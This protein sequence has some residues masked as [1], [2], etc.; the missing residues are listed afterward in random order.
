MQ[1]H[2]SLQ[3]AEQ[4]FD[5]EHTL[6]LGLTLGGDRY[7]DAEDRKAFFDQLFSRL[8]A[9]PGLREAGAVSKLPLQGGTNGR[10]FT[11]EMISVD[12]GGRGVLTENSTVTGDYFGAMG[13]PLLAGRTLQPEDDDPESPGVVINRAAAARFWPDE[14]PLGKRLSFGDDPP[15]WLTVVGVV[16]D[17]RQWGPGVPPRPEAYMGY[18]VN[19]RTRM[20]I[21]VAGAGDPRGLFRP[22]RDAVLAVDPNQPLSEIQTMG[23]ILESQLAGREFYTFLIGLFSVLAL[24]LAAA[25]VYGVISY[26]VAQ[27][28][29]ELGIRVALGAGRR[30]LI[31]LVVRRAIV[32]VLAGIGFGLVGVAVATLTISSLLYGIS[33]V[34]LPTLAGGITILLAVGT[35]AALF[36]GFRATRLSPVEALR[37]E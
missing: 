34:D 30:G 17:V 1:S 20:F 35:A 11:E 31:R 14:D 6:T 23:D 25:G 12:P 29:R 26:F 7:L 33:P 27:R 9:I 36:P 5:E 2:T 24:G 13:I 16:G 28:T 15:R 19:P 18:L 8:G 32:L 10:V 4:G 3:R 21:T 22:V 37:T